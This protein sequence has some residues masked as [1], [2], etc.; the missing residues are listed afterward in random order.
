MFAAVSLSLH[1]F[2]CLLF[3]NIN[4]IVPIYF[5]SRV[6]CLAEAVKRRQWE[7]AYNWLAILISFNLRL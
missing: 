6:P 4:I 2:F 3:S 7:L 5:R 1:G